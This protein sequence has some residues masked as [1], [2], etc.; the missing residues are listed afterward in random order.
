MGR[1]SSG[2]VLIGDSWKRLDPD[3][4]ARHVFW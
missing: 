1:L 4:L 2:I 3:G